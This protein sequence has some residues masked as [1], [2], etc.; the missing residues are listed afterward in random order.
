M[1]NSIN[2]L[3]ALGTDN[4]VRYICMFCF[5]CNIV[6]MFLRL[7]NDCVLIILNFIY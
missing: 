1:V 4:S 6:I 3:L 5:L 7:T 2:S